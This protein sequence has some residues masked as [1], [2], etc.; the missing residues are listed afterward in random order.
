MK[1]S[2]NM[3]KIRVNITKLCDKPCKLS[4]RNL[5][6]I[7]GKYKLKVVQ[8]LYII[9]LDAPAQDNFS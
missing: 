5:V 1:I 7:N 8:D 2:A 3:P 9:F 6:V 4:N